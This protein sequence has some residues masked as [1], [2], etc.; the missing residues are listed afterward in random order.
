MDVQMKDLRQDSGRAD[1]ATA[2]DVGMDC[3]L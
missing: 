2:S 3:L 1:E